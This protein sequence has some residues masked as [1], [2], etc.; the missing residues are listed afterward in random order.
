MR[1][2]EPFSSFGKPLTKGKRNPELESV[3]DSLI[4]RERILSRQRNV[5]D[6]FQKKADHAFQGEF[7]ALTRLSEAQSELDRREWKMRNADV[8]LHETG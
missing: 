2:V 5:F 6:L 8:A 7:A 1:D 3:Q 4:A